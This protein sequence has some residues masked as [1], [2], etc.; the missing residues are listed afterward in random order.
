VSKTRVND[1]LRR[2]FVSPSEFSAIGWVPSETLCERTPEWLVRLS[3]NGFFCLT[4]ALERR[5]YLTHPEYGRLLFDRLAAIEIGNREQH[6][7]GWFWFGRRDPE[8][9]L[10]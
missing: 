3:W 6:V 8:S 7:S 4:T 2:D 10:Q 5:V 1:L 9:M